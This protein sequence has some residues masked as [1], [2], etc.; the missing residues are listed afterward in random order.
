[1]S[2]F[3]QSSNENGN[4]FTGETICV[5]EDVQDVA[6]QYYSWVGGWDDHDNAEQSPLFD[7]FDEAAS[8]ALALVTA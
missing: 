3:E 8:W 1:M 4:L 2:G 5:F 7:T 6:P